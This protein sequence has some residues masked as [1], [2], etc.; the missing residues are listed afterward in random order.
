[1]ALVDIRLSIIK[2][3]GYLVS[4]LSDAIDRK[5]DK[6]VIDSIQA[7]I[8]KLKKAYEILNGEDK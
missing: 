1:M 4:D 7:D 8:D 3:I 5:M 2:E 6:F